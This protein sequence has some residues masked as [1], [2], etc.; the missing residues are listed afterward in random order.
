M[1]SLRVEL[2]PPLRDAAGVGS[3][4]IQLEDGAT[5]GGL[6]EALVARFG[7][8]FRRHLF[9]TE[10]KIIPSWNVIINKEVVQMNKAEAPLRALS[11]G[12]DVAII[13]N[14]AGGQRRF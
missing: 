5:V 2:Y 9:D 1:I 8:E 7:P 12:D 11:T 3:L 4:D 14:I 13:M 6:L 10:G